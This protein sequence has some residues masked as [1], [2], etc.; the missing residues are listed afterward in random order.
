MLGVDFSS[1][2]CMTVSNEPGGKCPITGL[3]VVAVG[4]SCQWVV[5][6]IPFVLHH[7]V[8]IGGWFVRVP[9]FSP[10]S[11]ATG[12]SSSIFGCFT[13]QS[14]FILI[15]AP[16]V[17]TSVLFVFVCLFLTNI[18]NKSILILK[19]V[20]ISSVFEPALSFVWLV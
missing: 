14:T 5:F 20:C 9:F 2:S 3:K 8:Y 1:S 18:L 11:S 13:S 7:L 19:P 6:H 15:H 4:P 12:K 17:L 10:W 16:L